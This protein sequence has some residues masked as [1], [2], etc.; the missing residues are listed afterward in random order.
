[1]SDEISL[2]DG[3]QNA[4]CPV[5][6]TDSSGNVWIAWQG[7]DGGAFHIRAVRQEDKTFGKPFVVS[8]GLQRNCWSP[9]I[10]TTSADGGRVAI[11]WDGYEK[12]DYDVFVREYSNDG[13][14]DAMRP[15]ANTPNYESRASLAYDGAG[16]MWIAW[17]QSGPKWGKD[18]GAYDKD[19][20]IGLYKNRTVG[21][22]VLDHGSWKEPAQPVNAALP[23]SARGDVTQSDV[24]IQKQR[25]AEA[26]KASNGGGFAN[27]EKK[28]PRRK[29]QPQPAERKAGEEA[30]TQGPQILN[31]CARIASDRE[32]RIWLLCRTK[33]GAF[34]TPV[35][36]VWCDYAAYY[37]GDRWTGPVLVPHSDN[38]LFNMPS[39]A[40]AAHGIRLAHSTDH[41]QDKLTVWKKNRVLGNGAGNAALGATVDPFVNDVYV[42]DLA[43]G[44]QAKPAV[45]VDAKSKPVDDAKP[46]DYT[47]K[48]RS[49]VKAIRDYRMNL[50]GTELKILRGE[51]HR[52]TEISGDGGGDGPLEDMWRYALDVA[53]MDWI[54]NGD[55]DNGG[56]R[57]YPWWLTQKTT[58]AYHLPGRFD[59]MFTYERSVSYPEGHRNVIF[60]QRG[61]RTLARLPI[62][63]AFNPK[64]APDTQMLYKYL[65]QFNGV[66][67]SHTSATAMGTDWRDND[68]ALEPFV[69]IYQ[70]ARQNYERP[71]APR[72]PTAEDA[73]GGWE[74]KGMINLALLKG[75]RL[76][77]ESSSDH[78]STHISSVQIRAGQIRA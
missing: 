67:A 30:A 68:P 13:K 64:P 32:G 5:A 6:A 8:D 65:R 42:S 35:G 46:A 18:W 15:V 12:G 69:E 53:N 54:G 9:A 10:A 60:V 71:G 72:C 22:R 43:Q 70:G 36:S 76:A 2:T 38:L 25:E 73:I 58:D 78:G 63:D 39:M 77:F 62:S 20:G 14:A 16:R 61:I 34:H 52:H 23:V 44:G 49:D 40:A 37:D 56:G 45:L 24:F 11:A 17:E 33:Q 19:D 4:L 66:C 75:Y 59:P 1:M 47:A 74:P 21:L 26:L 50:N 55:H 41:R 29:Q 27:E 7:A 28:G 48:E 31:S 57:E 51:F 3:R